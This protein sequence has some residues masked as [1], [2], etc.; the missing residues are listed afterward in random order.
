MM[1]K[2]LMNRISIVKPTEDSHPC[3]SSIAPNATKS[4]RHIMTQLPPALNPTLMIP[5]HADDV[6]DPA[7]S[8]N[9]KSPRIPFEE[10]VAN[11]AT[12]AA[13]AAAEAARGFGY[14]PESAE[15]PADKPD[16]EGAFAIELLKMGG[17][18]DNDFP[19]LC[20]SPPAGLC[21]L[22][23]LKHIRLVGNRIGGAHTHSSIHLHLHLHM[24]MPCD[25]PIL[26]TQ[27]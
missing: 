9:A 6:V 18:D 10:E 4:F 14:Q 7:N 19:F 3:I 16:N 17:D 2:Y 11:A 15:E 20:D 23:D 5:P 8:G 22:P 1:V 27:C 13:E 26:Y 24:H 25:L 12:A 21:A